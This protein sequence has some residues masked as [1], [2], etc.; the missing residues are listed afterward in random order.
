M[1]GTNLK[2]N[3]GKS[4]EGTFER[5]RVEEGMKGSE[6]KGSSRL[7]FKVIFVNGF[8]VLV[9]LPTGTNFRK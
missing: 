4:K 6:E 5:E 1:T 9:R 3:L 7:L 2:V 8:Q